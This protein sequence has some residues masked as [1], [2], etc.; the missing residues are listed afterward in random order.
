MAAEASLGLHLKSTCTSLGYEHREMAEWFAST[1]NI[2]RP[3]AGVEF[4]KAEN[5]IRCEAALPPRS[6]ATGQ[7]PIGASPVWHQAA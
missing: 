3:L 2:E 6:H 5:C 1:S 7:P 4:R